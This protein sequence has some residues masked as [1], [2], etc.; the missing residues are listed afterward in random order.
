MPTATD[1]TLRR[2]AL[3]DRVAV[4]DLA[5]P[6]FTGMTGTVTAINTDPK[7]EGDHDP[8]YSIHLD[9]DT[10]PDEAFWPWELR[11]LD[12]YDS[13]NVSQCVTLLRAFPSFF[14]ALSGNEPAPLLRDYA[15]RLSEP[16]SVDYR[17]HHD[18]YLLSLAASLDLPA[19]PSPLSEILLDADTRALLAELD[20]R[21][22]RPA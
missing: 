10:S 4:T 2:F 11:P 1:P 18:A 12:R 22:L 13:L 6:F 15:R 8:L 14:D 5:E 7:Y 3:R 9:D 20:R 17:P 16:P 21:C 19:S